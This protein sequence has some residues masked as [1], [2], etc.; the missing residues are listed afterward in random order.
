MEG[1]NGF[2]MQEGGFDNV[3]AYVVFAHDRWKLRMVY[4]INESMSCMLP[5]EHGMECLFDITLSHS[6]FLVAMNLLEM[7]SQSQT[8]ATHH[9]PHRLDASISRHAYRLPFLLYA[10]TLPNAVSNFVA[11]EQHRGFV[12][13]VR[14]DEGYPHR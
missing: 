11:L 1:G 10:V 9:T 14:K 6:L 4:M 2:A 3:F 13:Q 8:S 5:T 12:L 7:H